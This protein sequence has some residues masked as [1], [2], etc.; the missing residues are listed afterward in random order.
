MIVVSDTS[1]LSGLAIAG[2]LFLLQQIYGQVVIPTAVAD[3]LRRG[4]QYDLR[5]QDVLALDWVEIRQSTNCA[6]VESLQG[7]HNL[8]HGEA[9]AIALALELKADEL[10]IDERLGR[11]VAKRLGLPITGLLGILLV[12]KQQG[13]IDAVRPI[14][15]TLIQ[16]AGFRVSYQLYTE[17]L[18][19]AGENTSGQ[20]QR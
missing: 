5:I 3:E 2:Y 4:G 16:E 13:R 9:E 15:D 10:L 8:D 12:A 7:D 1:P 6:L 14:V 18:R 11:R 19:V 20:Q 17:V